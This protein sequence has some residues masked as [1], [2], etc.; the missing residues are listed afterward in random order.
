MGRGIRTAPIARA[1]CATI[2]VPHPPPY[3]RTGP[4]ASN[5]AAVR[6]HRGLGSALP[7]SV[8]GQL[9]ARPA[10]SA[11]ISHHCRCPARIQLRGISPGAGHRAR[12]Q[13]RGRCGR[14]GVCRT[15]RAHRIRGRRPGRSG[16][17][18][19]AP[20]GAGGPALRQLPGH[21][22]VVIRVHQRRLEGRRTARRAL[23]PGA[24]KTHRTR[25]GQR[26][27]HEDRVFRIDHYLG[28]E[29]VQNLLALRFG[30]A[31]S[32]RCGTALWIESRADH[33][34]R[35]R[36]GV[37]G[38]GAT[39]T[40]TARCATWCRTT[41][42]NCSAWSPWSRQRIAGRRLGARRE[43]QGAARRCADDRARGRQQPDACAA[44]TRPASSTESRP[45]LLRGAGR[46]ADTSPTETFVALRADI[47]NWRWAGV[48][49]LPAH[50]QAAGR[51]PHADRDPRFASRLALALRKTQAGAGGRPTAWCCD[52]SPRRISSSI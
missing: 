40:T 28:K 20:R 11:G 37:E 38:R 34:G 5:P 9:A 30:N 27:R 16:Q 36:F 32:S 26:A 12:R 52:C 17:H 42:C 7:L 14:T 15:A 46:P 41:C 39:T 51:A 18:R 24:G 29:T 22:A 44:S 48:P 4:H 43:G 31:L 45:G 8:P 2:G 19:A 35:D 49:F 33:R 23:A 25:P 3:R 47:D 6:R 50:R 1:L 13:S 21:A 10:A